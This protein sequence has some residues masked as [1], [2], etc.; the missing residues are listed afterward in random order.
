MS[1]AIL[2][3]NQ[4]KN[5]S[6]K[7]PSLPLSTCTQIRDAEYEDRLTRIIISTAIDKRARL[8]AELQQKQLPNGTNVNIVNRLAAQ[9][10]NTTCT[11]LLATFPTEF[12][13]ERWVQFIQHNFDRIYNLHRQTPTPTKSKS[14]SFTY[15]EITV[16]QMPA[17]RLLNVKLGEDERK[18]FK[19]LL[20]KAAT[21]ITD[22]IATVALAGRLHIINYAKTGLPVQKYSQQSQQYLPIKTLCPEAAVRDT[23]QLHDHKMIPVI[24]THHR[25]AE[26]MERDKDIEE[27]LS[28]NHLS[29][30]LNNINN[31]Q[32]KDKHTTWQACL[33]NI[34]LSPSYIMNSN[35]HLKSSA[36]RQL[37]TNVSNMWRKKDL[38]WRLLGHT[39]RLLIRLHLAPTREKRRYLKIS[40]AKV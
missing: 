17:N 8:K 24:P 6:R 32:E 4:K 2:R 20:V 16:V 34:A 33:K 30:I 22:T 28:M 37:A 10:V 19:D 23:S 3:T 39:S 13:K 18:I 26:F 31:Q 1:C 9:G 21:N 27:F 7:D 35:S 14:S 38:Y 25:I 29:F 36:V 40:G 11:A 12:T 15:E 5:T